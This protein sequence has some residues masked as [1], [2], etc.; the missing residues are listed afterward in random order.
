MLLYAG[1]TADVSIVPCLP[2][3]A[4]IHL[5]YFYFATII[6]GTPRSVAA[7]GACY[8]DGQ[9]TINCN[10]IKYYNDRY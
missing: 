8:D 1:A 6:V 3:I 7:K 10:Q 2:C 4:A 9:K 5:N